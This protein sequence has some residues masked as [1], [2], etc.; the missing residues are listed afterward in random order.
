[1]HRDRFP[2]RAGWLLGA[3]PLAALLAAC[4]SGSGPLGDGGVVATQCI[5]FPAGK[6]VTTGLYELTNSGTKPVTVQGIALR[7]RSGLTVTNT[8]LV[9]IYHD[10]KNGDWF[11]VGVG[12]PY[13]PTTAPEWRNRRPAIGATIRPGQDLN[14]VFGLTRTTAKA[15]R[16]DGPAIAYTAGGSGYSMKEKTSLVVAASCN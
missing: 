16:S 12:A 15:G 8:W 6:P 3:L 5:S 14:L 13:P 9:P 7:N 11:D 4:S 1:L 2:V 10:L